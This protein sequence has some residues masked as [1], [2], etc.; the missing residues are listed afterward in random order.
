MKLNTLQD[1]YVE[2]LHDLMDAEE[3][4]EKALDKMSDKASY[5]ELKNAFMEHR[6]QTKGHAQ[7]LEEIFENLGEKPKAQKCKGI[8]GIIDESED[9]AKA[10]GDAA[11]IDAGL[12]A[13]AQRAEHYEIAAYGTVA[14]YA[15]MLGRTQDVQLLRQTLEEEKE[16][17][18]KL[19]SLAERLINV[20]AARAAGRERRVS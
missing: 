6:E 17:D 18:R 14:T 2:Q 8:R 15:E 1:L 20:D 9:L 13:S 19:T 11:S 4:L 12:I 3:Q 5:T 10:S 16:T 7:R